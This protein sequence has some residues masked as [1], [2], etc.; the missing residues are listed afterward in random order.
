MI[1]DNG[2]MLHQ[3]APS[4]ARRHSSDSFSG[5]GLENIKRRIQLYYGEKADLELYSI[6]DTYTAAELSLPFA[7]SENTVPIKESHS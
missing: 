1:V 2:G 3:A 4:P 7:I 5:I 6:G